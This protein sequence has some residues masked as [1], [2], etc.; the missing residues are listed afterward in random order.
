VAHTADIERDLGFQLGE[1]A[2]HVVVDL[3]MDV[4]RDREVLEAFAIAGAPE[5]F[6]EPGPVLVH[7]AG[8]EAHRQPA[9]GDLG[10]QLHRRLVAGGEI[11]RDVGV[12]VQDGFQRL[13]DAHGAGAG[14]GQRDLAA[15]VADGA[16]ALKNLAHDRD[17]VAHAPVGLAPGLAVPALD[18]L[19][20]GDADAGEEAAA[21]RHGIDG[22][23]RHGGVGGRAGGELHDAGAEFYPLGVGGQERERRH[24][25][26]AVGFGRPHGIVAQLLGALHELHGDI[27]GG[28]GIADGEA[29]LHLVSSWEIRPYHPAAPDQ[30]GSC[31]EICSAIYGSGACHC[32]DH[33]GAGFHCDR[34]AVFR[35]QEVMGGGGPA[36]S[37]STGRPSPRSRPRPGDHAPVGQGP[38]SVEDR[39]LRVPHRHLRA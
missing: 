26:G 28:T 7:G 23:G 31:L 17:V 4:R 30:Q 24:R 8:H 19:R 2:L 20:T 16:F 13:A 5:T 15:F 38:L 33:P 18:D 22:R 35:P 3:D 25:V 21:A 1:R 37:L 36:R 9:V 27:E 32:G 39:P 6:F 14:V 12:H 29:E 11:D 10:G 34:D